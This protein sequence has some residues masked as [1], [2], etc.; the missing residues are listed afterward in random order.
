MSRPQAGFG[1]RLCGS[2]ACWSQGA[3]GLLATG[4]SVYSADGRLGTHLG[5]SAGLGCPL[6]VRMGSAALGLGE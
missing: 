3:M 1:V 2:V 4:Q 5:S 6:G